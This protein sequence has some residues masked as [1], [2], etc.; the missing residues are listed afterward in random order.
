MNAVVLGVVLLPTIASLLWVPRYFPV[1][2]RG[3]P[4]ALVATLLLAGIVCVVT[5]VLA[6]FIGCSG[7]ACN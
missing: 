4:I 1:D 6:F 5:A 3:R 2:W 7:G